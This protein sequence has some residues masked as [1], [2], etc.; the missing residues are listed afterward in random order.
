VSRG[1]PSDYTEELAAEICSLVSD[2]ET[3]NRIT[4]RDDMP[5][6]QTLY[7]W[8]NKYPE[9]LDN[10][11]RAREER[12]DF[13]FDQVTQVIDDMRNEVIK[14]EMARIEIDAIKWMAGKEKPKKYGDSSMVK[15]ADNE[16]NKLEGI[17][18]NLIPTSKD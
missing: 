8:F 11:T 2:G 4:K 3:I 5:S 7:T 17:D 1:R 9:F 18:V 6:R 12:A 16:G 14:P 13:R 15:L 10:Y